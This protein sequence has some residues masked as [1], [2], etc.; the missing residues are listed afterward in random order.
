VIVLVLELEHH[1]AVSDGLSVLVLHKELVV[2]S[3]V[4]QEG[5]AKL[6][7]MRM[8]VNLELFFF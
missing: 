4:P 5:L 1:Q 2:P 3:H 7:V 6:E 8:V